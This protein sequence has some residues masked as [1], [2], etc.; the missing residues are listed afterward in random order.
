MLIYCLK[1]KKDSE[2]VNSKML[3]TRNGRPML[4]SKCAVW[5]SK[6]SKFIKEQEEKGLLSSLG[7]KTPLSKVSLLGDVL[8]WGLRLLF[9]TIFKRT[10]CLLVILNEILWKEI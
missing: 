4:S 10:I 3:K 1:C 5:D 9:F 7:L 8:F 6:K 2:K